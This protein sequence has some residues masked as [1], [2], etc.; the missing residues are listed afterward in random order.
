MMPGSKFINKLKNLKKYG[1]LVEI[2]GIKL[3]IFPYFPHIRRL[4]EYEWRK[5]I[6]QRSVVSIPV[7]TQLIIVHKENNHFVLPMFFT[8]TPHALILHSNHMC[9]PSPNIRGGPNIPP[10]LFSPN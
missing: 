4:Y 8:A 7:I 2:I 3:E 6:Q 5:F 9:H 1:S 10:S